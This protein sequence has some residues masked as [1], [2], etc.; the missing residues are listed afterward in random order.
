M[1]LLPNERG[2]VGLLFL[3]LAVVLTFFIGYHGLLN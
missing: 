3:L 2:G 1:S